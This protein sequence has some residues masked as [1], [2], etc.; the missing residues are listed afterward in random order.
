ML[1]YESTVYPGVTEDECVPIL[2]KIS[3]L[4]YKADFGVGYSPERI[5]PGDKLH[6]LETIQ[7]IVSGS[8]SDTLNVVADLYSDIIDAGIFK[9]SNIRTAEAAK[10][11]ENIQRDVNISL[12]NVTFYYF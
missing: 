12:I 6:R 3:G 1:I 11:I 8:D 9:C 10:V 7:K 2:E 4:K 5:N